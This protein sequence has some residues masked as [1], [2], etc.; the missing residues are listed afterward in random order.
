MEY[1]NGF[2]EKSFKPGM[3]NVNNQRNII[4]LNRGNCKL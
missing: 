1:F 4:I 3:R 2:E